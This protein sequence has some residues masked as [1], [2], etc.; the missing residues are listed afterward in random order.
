[1]QWWQRQSKEARDEALDPPPTS[2]T[3]YD[4]GLEI[5]FTWVKHRE[6]YS[7]GADTQM[8]ANDPDADCTWLKHSAMA[9]GLELPWKYWDHRSCRTILALGEEI[10]ISRYAFKMKG[11]AHNALDDA[12]HQAG[13][14][15][16][17][18]QKFLIRK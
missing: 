6:L 3:N 10:G 7:G 11:T 4:E 15:S 5:F 2:V 18:W 14:V 8:W 16:T 13:Y 1:M 9:C 17:I 12:I